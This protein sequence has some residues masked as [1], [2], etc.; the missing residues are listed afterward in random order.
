MRNLRASVRAL[1]TL[2]PSAPRL[3]Q[4]E[5]SRRWQLDPDTCRRLIREFNLPATSGPGGRDRY[6]LRD[7]WRIEGLSN[8][9]FQDS[10]APAWWLLPL[11]TAA[12]LADLF[13]V[14]PACIRTWVRTG[15]IPAVRLGQSLRFHARDILSDEELQALCDRSAHPPPKPKK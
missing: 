11:F 2:S 4:A 3:S 1:K 10:S 9:P 15:R 12:D 7:I 13:E 5:I 8:V 14:T 6:S